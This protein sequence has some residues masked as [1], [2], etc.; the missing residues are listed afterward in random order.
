MTWSILEFFHNMLFLAVE[1]KFTHEEETAHIFKVSR[2]TSFFVALLKSVSF[3]F[4]FFVG[5][6]AFPGVVFQ[7][8]FQRTSSS[9]RVRL[10]VCLYITRCGLCLIV[11]CYLL[12]VIYILVQN[13]IVDGIFIVYT[14]VVSKSRLPMTFWMLF[15][16]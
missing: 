2:K 15:A 5:C 16:K 4:F 11:I 8:G 9:F 6:Y 3:S 1:S 10:F 7:N 14:Y 13:L 12:F